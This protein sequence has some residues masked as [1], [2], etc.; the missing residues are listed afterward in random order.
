MSFKMGD[1]PI[2]SCSTIRKSKSAA[3]L[4]FTPFRRCVTGNGDLRGSAKSVD[5]AV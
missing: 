2:F 3:Q 4:A 5:Y 1:S